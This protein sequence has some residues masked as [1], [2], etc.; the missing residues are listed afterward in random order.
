LFL[1]LPPAITV[2]LG[3]PQVPEDWSNQKVLAFV[4]LMWRN[5]GKKRGPSQDGETEDVKGPAPPAAVAAAAKIALASLGNNPSAE[6]YVEP[7]KAETYNDIENSELSPLIPPSAALIERTSSG[8]WAVASASDEAGEQAGFL[9]A[10]TE[11]SAFGR[12]TTVNH[13]VSGYHEA[14]LDNPEQRNRNLRWLRTHFRPLIDVGKLPFN[15]ADM[16]Q[17]HQYYFSPPYYGDDDSDSKPSSDHDD[18]KEA[19]MDSA[20]AKPRKMTTKQR[21]VAPPSTPVS[22]SSQNPASMGKTIS[23]HALSSA[24]AA[25]DLTN[26]SNK[27]RVEGEDDKEE[28]TKHSKVTEPSAK[29]TKSMKPRIAYY[30]RIRVSRF[31][32]CHI[33]LCLFASLTKPFFVPQARLES[34]GTKPLELTLSLLRKLKYVENVIFPQHTAYEDLDRL[35]ESEHATRL[36]VEMILLDLI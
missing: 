24:V 16:W 33:I 18:E 12:L 11:S 28:D 20:T 21:L 23:F 29:R 31:G 19:S 13:A 32:T 30:P 36:D 15:N 2:T 7:R 3:M 25:A 9:E 27:R 10:W 6:L 1:F 34:L 8:R 14:P 17:L 5:W 22:S 35:R 26:G 4:R